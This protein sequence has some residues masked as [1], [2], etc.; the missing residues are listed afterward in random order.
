MLPISFKS[1]F[2]LLA[3]F[4]I[5]NKVLKHEN[6]LVLPKNLLAIIGL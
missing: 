6:K 5:D 4:Q 3:Y 2:F 1:Y